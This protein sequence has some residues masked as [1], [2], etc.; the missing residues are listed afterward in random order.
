M[1]LALIFSFSS[2]V[3]ATEDP[4]KSITTITVESGGYEFQITESVN[5]NYQI[6]RTYTKD[7]A[8]L[9]ADQI[10]DAN[11]S[12]IRTKSLLSALGISQNAIEHLDTDTLHSFANGKSISVISSYTKCDA[13]GNIVPVSE[14][15][16]LQAAAEQQ[17]MNLQ[18]LTNDVPSIEPYELNHSSDSYM[19]IDLYV[20]YLGNA[21][22]L[23][24]ADARWLTMPKFRLT[25]SFGI[26]A[27]GIDVTNDTRSGYWDYVEV[28]RNSYEGT[29]ETRKTHTM[30]S[31]ECR[32]AV[33]GNWYG[34]AE[35]FTL[36][37]DFPSSIAS[38]YCKDF[39]AHFQFY[40][41]IHDYTSGKN[42]TASA[43]Y[44]H[45]KIKLSPS[46]SIGID[47]NKAASVSGCIGLQFRG[48]KD[49]RG[50]DIS[51]IH[52]VP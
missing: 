31:S 45:S 43:C 48:E 14:T 25:D 50:V 7:P 19:K 9:S 1:S 17:R 27:M 24:A 42:F 36:P 21:R 23:F 28:S 32:N 40:A 18:N 26:C 3:F 29:K 5:E 20:S 8:P 38:S 47:F 35:F 10:D 52:Y 46:I 44:V 16:A 49:I 11:Q 12:Y 6:T 51:N 2:Q 4:S 33:N 30:T 15:E 37:G 13:D 39:H 22:Y 41:L 34:S